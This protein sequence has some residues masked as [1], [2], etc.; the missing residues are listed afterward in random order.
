MEIQ[1]HIQQHQKVVVRI[2]TRV[3]AGAGAEKHYLGA[4]VKFPNSRFYGFSY[5]SV[6]L[7]HNL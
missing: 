4:R 1:W 2:L 5:G 7:I 6:F 3:S